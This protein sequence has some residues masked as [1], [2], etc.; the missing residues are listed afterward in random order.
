[1][2]PSGIDTGNLGTRA[3]LAPK[4]ALTFQNC[5]ALAAKFQEF[6][7]QGKTEIILDCKAVSFIDSAALELLIKI[8]DD[9]K[10]RG[11]VLKLIELDEVCAD[12]LLATR[13]INVFFVYENIHQAVKS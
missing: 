2:T 3:V 12:I 13:L 11:G 8:H 5:K 7:N 1:M 9:L 4:E 10:A 6:M